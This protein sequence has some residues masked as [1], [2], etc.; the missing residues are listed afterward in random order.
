MSHQPPSSSSQAPLL[1]HHQHHHLQHQYHQKPPPAFSSAPPLSV[2]VADNLLSVTT[3]GAQA[4][5]VTH[6][7]PI[8]GGDGGDT[9]QSV[10]ETACHS[11]PVDHDPMREQRHHLMFKNSGDSLPPT[12][13]GEAIPVLADSSHPQRSHWDQAASSAQSVMI[14]PS[15]D[16]QVSDNSLL[17][18]HH[19]QQHSHQLLAD[20]D[21]HVWRASHHHHHHHQQQQEQQQTSPEYHQLI[22]DPAGQLMTL[23]CMDTQ[24]FTASSTEQLS[25][26]PTLVQS[27]SQ[28]QQQYH[29]STVAGIDVHQQQQQQLQLHPAPPPLCR[30]AALHQPLVPPRSRVS[31]PARTGRARSSISMLVSRRR[32]MAAASARVSRSVAAAS[33]GRTADVET[34]LAV[35]SG[36]GCEE[37]VSASATSLSPTTRA[38][39]PSRLESSVEEVERRFQSGCDCSTEQSCFRSLNAAMV[40][41]HRLNIAEL[42][43]HEHDMYLMG[44]T[45]ACMANPEETARRKERKR[46]HARYVFRGRE[47]CLNAFLYL[48]NCTHYQVKRIRK[49]VTTHGVTPRVHGNHRRLPVNTLSLPTYHHVRR[50]L[51]L[52]LARLETGSYNKRRSAGGSLLAPPYL[53]RKAVHYGYTQY[54]QQHAP[55]Q[56][57][58]TY[59]AFLHF[60]RTNFGRLRFSSS[61]SGSTSSSGSA[62][63]NDLI[64]SE[65]VALLSDVM[66]DISEDMEEDGGECETAGSLSRCEVVVGLSDGACSASS[67]TQVAPKPSTAVLDSQSGDSESIMFSGRG[68]DVPLKQESSSFSVDPFAVD[69]AAMVDSATVSQDS[70]ANYV[71]NSFHF[72]VPI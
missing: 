34:D 4:V 5:N 35:E 1:Q 17:Q 53:T 49:H 41:Q 7:V 16:S 24:C 12:D 60:L 69:K 21:H 42:N 68:Y 58:M 14:M 56:R 40:F 71:D 37:R 8:S 18:C 22:H 61:G 57:P 62:P 55:D 23:T 70:V 6:A 33:S 51:S 45:M 15:A 2:S 31:S 38:S 59:S 26:A 66:A 54:M 25:A 32:R 10:G 39:E 72:S 44:V 28:P 67:S 20:D 46:M 47:V 36:S 52:L 50:F 43:R 13:G 48:E 9:C 63:A 27:L 19:H 30:P 11:P 65:F 29:F 64:N 3:S